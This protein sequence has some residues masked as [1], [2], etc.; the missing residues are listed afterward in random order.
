MQFEERQ[1]DSVRKNKGTQWISQRWTL[2]RFD[3]LR[4]MHDHIFDVRIQRNKTKY[5]KCLQ[6][7]LQMLRILLNFTDM[8]LKIIM[9]NS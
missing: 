7:C 6:Y 3:V 5:W 4:V 8:F 2:K 1:H 9:Q